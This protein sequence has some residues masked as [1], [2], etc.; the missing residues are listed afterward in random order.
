MET[1]NRRDFLVRAG[2]VAAGLSL[3][4]WTEALAQARPRR[5]VVLFL[6]GGLDGLSVLVPYEDKAYYQARPG[7]ALA[8]PGQEGGALPLVPGFGLHPAL[9][10]L[11]ELWREHSLAVIPSCGLPTPVRTHP[12]AQKAMESGQPGERHYRDG[13][14]G[15]LA[16]LLGKDVTGITLST[17]QTLVGQ[18]SK[19]IQ[20][21]RPSGY[22]PSIWRLERPAV[23]SA[24]DAIYQGNDALSRAYRQAQ[25][26]LRNKLTE[27]DRE[28]AVSASGAP[29]I[30][31]LPTMAA[32]IASFLEKAPPSARLVFAALG[33]L[34][35]HFQQGTVTGR[36]AEAFTSL[37][38]G[39]ALLAKALGPNLS[40]T[41]VVV[42]SEFGRGLREN[43]FA[44]TENGHGTVCMV[45]GGG[46]AGGAL[47]GPWPGLAAEKLSGGLDPAVAV[48]FREVIAQVC[49]SHLEVNRE[50]L[51]QVLHG[52]TPTGLLK[53]LF[54]P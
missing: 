37:G 29:S 46:V 52:Y 21:I 48:D 39:L 30:H 35:A 17:N 15:R 42:M 5:L 13:W 23:Y 2:I 50:Q 8:P 14:M 43:E 18:G 36:Q 26:A 1:M 20:N 41:C 33:G 22:P 31:S 44:G 12:E 25:V 49:M 19:A 38:K 9:E 28:I 4:A 45:L 10:P 40:N 6:R 53:D 24:Y 47:R 16:P 3:P 34:D 51:A 27:L 54:T 11:L 7:I 32:Q